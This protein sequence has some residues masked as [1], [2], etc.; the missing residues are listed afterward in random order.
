MSVF[1]RRNGTVFEIRRYFPIQ[2]RAEHFKRKMELAT[3]GT[4]FPLLCRA[5]HR[6]N[7]HRFAGTGDGDL[8]PAFDP[9]N[10]ARQVRLGE[11]DVDGLSH[12]PI[13]A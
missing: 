7:R 5:H 4:E 6:Q 10:Q 8:F 9:L 11:M 1:I 13:L 12:D 2:L 3:Q